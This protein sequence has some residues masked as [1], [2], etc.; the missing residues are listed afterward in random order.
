M[1]PQNSETKNLF[2]NKNLDEDEATSDKNSALKSLD[3]RIGDENLLKIHP[4]EVKYVINSKTGRKV[5]KIICKIQGCNG[6]FDK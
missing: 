3:H 6:I 2:I 5:K 4:N 1:L